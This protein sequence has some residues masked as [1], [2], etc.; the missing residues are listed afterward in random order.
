MGIQVRVDR[1]MCM[2]TGECVFTA[3]TVFELDRDRKAV[4][5]DATAADQESILEAANGC[6]NFAITVTDDGNPPL[7]P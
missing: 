5:K 7:G 2:G 6:P 3:P 1:G 4:V